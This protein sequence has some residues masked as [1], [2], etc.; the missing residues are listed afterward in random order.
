MGTEVAIRGPESVDKQLKKPKDNI[1]DDLV[2]FIFSLIVF[3]ER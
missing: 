2:C 3:L 1:D